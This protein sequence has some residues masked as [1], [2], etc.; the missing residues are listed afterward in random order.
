[1]NK[2]ASWG[3]APIWR[4]SDLCLILRRSMPS[5]RIVPAVGSYSRWSS[6]IIVVLPAPLGPTSAT[7]SPGCTWKSTPS[8]TRVPSG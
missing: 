3:T 6:A 5:T 2:S 8:S 4:R 1:L 7:T